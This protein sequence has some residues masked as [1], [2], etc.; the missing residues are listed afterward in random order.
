MIL[1]IIFLILGIG[2]VLMGA[3]KFTDGACGIARKWKVSELVIGLTIVALGTSLP[4][5]MVSLFSVLGGSADMSVGNI[6]GSNCF[7]TLVIIGASSFMMDIAVERSLLRRDIP[8]SLFL[9]LLLFGMVFSDGTLDRMEAVILVFLFIAYIAYTFRI[10]M[11]DRASASDEVHQED[12]SMWQ[13]LLLILLGGTGLVLGGHLLVDNAASLARLWGVKE[14]II[15][16]TILAG[17]TSLPE[18]ATSMVAA[19]KGSDGLALGNAIGSNVF[20]IAFVLG[21]CG[22]IM[23]MQV[24]DISAVDW[25]ALIGSNILLWVLAFT[26]RK[27]CKWEGFVLL[28][29]YMLYLIYICSVAKV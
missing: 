28:L 16:L 25:I 9:A 20:N 5:F 6:V 26:G 17:G 18:L 8:G 29:A 23:P 3:D 2:L 13:L 12:K 11:K 15:G 27:L 22:T 19:R 10:A 7:N 24:S 4:E 1:N 21:L 14:S